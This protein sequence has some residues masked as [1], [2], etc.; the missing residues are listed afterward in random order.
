M[1]HAHLDKC[2]TWMNVRGTEKKSA[3]SS[4]V[5]EKQKQQQAFGE[6]GATAKQQQYKK[7]SNENPDDGDG[8]GNDINDDNRAHCGAAFCTVTVNRER[9]REREKKTRYKLPYDSH[10]THVAQCVNKVCI[11]VHV[12]SH[13]RQEKLATDGG[14]R[15]AWHGMEWNGANETKKITVQVILDVYSIHVRKFIQSHFFLC[16]P[17]S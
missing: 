3:L 11:N 1:K 15:M 16:T 4:I 9:E 6:I 17:T 13:I 5:R 14:H 7:T 8:N 2:C 12:V 10:N